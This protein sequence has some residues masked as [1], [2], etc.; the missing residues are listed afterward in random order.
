V[1]VVSRHARRLEGHWK[2]STLRPGH[3]RTLHLTVRIPRAA[4]G[5][6]CIT[7]TATAKHARGASDRDCV[8]V[9]KSHE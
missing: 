6:L 1:R 7:T 2:I 9:V 8:R 3:P 4:H 5:R